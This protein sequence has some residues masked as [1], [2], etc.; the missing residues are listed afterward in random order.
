MWSI[1]AK[2]LVY[3]PNKNLVILEGAALLNYDYTL[4]FLLYL[5]FATEG[6]KSGFLKPDIEWTPY[7]GT[8]IFVPYYFNLASNMDLVL[9]P[10][11]FT[12]RGVGLSSHYR[13]LNTC[14]RG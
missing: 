3:D 5:N 13:L 4:V 7:G 8:A 2:T 14:W 9:S 1:K 6:R 10:A 11:V 12:K